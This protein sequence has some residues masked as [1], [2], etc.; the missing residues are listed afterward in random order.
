M[1]A[2]QADQ[3]LF[4]DAYARHIILVSP[5]TLLASLRTVENIWRHEKQNQ[6]AEEIARQ[7]GGLYDQFALLIEAFEDIGKQI[8]KAS[9]AYKL[10]HKRL[11]T[12]R[13]NLIRRVESLRLLGAKT[14]KQLPV[15]QA[16]IDFQG[17]SGDEALDAPLDSEELMAED[18]DK[19]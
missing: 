13:G 4:Q 1:A 15:D 19:I 17:L 10:T 12:G 8:D 18:A 6:N 5:T 16:D 2:L 11:T 14:K 3:H 9:E 7:A